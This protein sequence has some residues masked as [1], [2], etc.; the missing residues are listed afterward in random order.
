VSQVKPEQIV[1]V[2]S[3]LDPYA[4]AALLGAWFLVLGVGMWSLPA[5]LVLAGIMLILGSA[6]AFLVKYLGIPAL[7]RILQKQQ[8]E[9]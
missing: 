5:A 1:L 7:V 6:F 2:K 4:V 3:K 8:R 9:K